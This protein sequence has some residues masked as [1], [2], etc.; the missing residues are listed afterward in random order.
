MT[1]RRQRTKG[2]KCTFWNCSKKGNPTFCYEHY[3]DY[4][5]GKVDDC[6][7]CGSGKDA[8]YPTCLNCKPSGK[9]SKPPSQSNPRYRREQSDTWQSRDSDATEF[10]V[11]ILKLNDA[12]FYAGQTRELRERLMEHQ[13]GTTRSTAGKEPKLAWFSTVST[14]EQATELEVELKKLCDRNPR[15]IRRWVRKFQDLVEALKFD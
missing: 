15:E 3:R 6:P 12:S 5:A 13:D 10:Y 1:T 8:S 14:R 4:K 9:S 11:Y 2:A 7:K